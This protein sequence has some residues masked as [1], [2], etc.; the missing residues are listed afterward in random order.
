[1]LFLGVFSK[2]EH[3][4]IGNIKFEFTKKSTNINIW[5]FNKIKNLLEKVIKL[6]LIYAVVMLNKNWSC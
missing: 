2:F 1:M 6:L 5:N 4:H 3:E